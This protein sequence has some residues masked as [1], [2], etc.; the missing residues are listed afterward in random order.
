MSGVFLLFK[1]CLFI[2][3]ERERERVSQPGRGREK[4]REPQ[5]G[6]TSPEL[7]SVLEPLN[8]E[9]MTPAEVKSQATN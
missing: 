1:V 4:G 5:A 8:L 6:S 9:I 7:T 2:L 3:R